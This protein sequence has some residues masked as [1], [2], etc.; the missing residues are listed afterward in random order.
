MIFRISN[1]GVPPFINFCSE[2]ILVISIFNKSLL[3]LLVLFVILVINTVYGLNIYLR[4]RYGSLYFYNKIFI[5]I[6]HNSKLIIFL[7]LLN[8]VVFIFKINIFYK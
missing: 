8:L 1:I 4:L 3:V 2:L 5:C 7:H 6:R